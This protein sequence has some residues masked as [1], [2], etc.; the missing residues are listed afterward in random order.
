M[1]FALCPL[2]KYHLVIALMLT[3]I[4]LERED[5]WCRELCTY[6]PYGLNDNVRGVGNISKQPGLVV[7][8]LFNRRYRKFKKRKHRRHRKKLN[9]NDLTSSVEN[10]LHS[11]KSRF[12]VFY[13]RS[14][15]LSLPVKWMGVLWNVFQCWRQTHDVPDRIAC[16]FFIHTDG[17]REWSN[18]S[19]GS[20]SYSP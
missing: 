9:L 14:L 7:N 17:S 15:V 1:I 6:Y 2:D 12:F 10:C 3:S 18:P 19:L 5:Y 4:R 8:A 16:C 11:Y 13:V 20:Y